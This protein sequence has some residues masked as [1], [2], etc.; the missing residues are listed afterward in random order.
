MNLFEI[1]IGR[2][3]K[4]DRQG[5]QVFVTVK[6]ERDGAIGVR[7]GDKVGTDGDPGDP[8]IDEADT[9]GLVWVE[10]KCVHPM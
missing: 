2:K 9:L 8:M 10:P 6:E 1:E 7:L 5:G 4:C 3:Y